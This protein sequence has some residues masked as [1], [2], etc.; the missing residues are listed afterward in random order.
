MSMWQL[1]AVQTKGSHLLSV[2]TV[3]SRPTPKLSTNGHIAR[4]WAAG[5]CAGPDGGDAPVAA[6]GAAGAA[7]ASAGWGAAGLGS[8]G[9]L[10]VLAGAALT[11]ALSASASDL[12]GAVSAAGAASV[13]SVA[14]VARGVGAGVGESRTPG[15]CAASSFRC[16]SDSAFAK[17]VTPRATSR[18][19]G[20]RAA[21]S[22]KAGSRSITSSPT[23]SALLTRLTGRAL[24]VAERARLFGFSMPLQRGQT[25]LSLAQ[26]AST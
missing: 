17:S 26:S 4:G 14:S 5:S 20:R 6:A 15:I 2:S 12:T 13:A 1:E 22:G 8:L 24:G 10:I 11:S 23:I 18:S 3:N 9:A 16:S 21:L 25:K 7:L 19:A